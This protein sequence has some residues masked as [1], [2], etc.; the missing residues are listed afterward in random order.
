MLEVLLFVETCNKNE[1][2]NMRGILSGEDLSEEF[3]QHLLE[4]G[5]GTVLLDKYNC[6]DISLISTSV[7]SLD[8]LIVRVFRNFQD[9]QQNHMYLNERAI[10]Q[11]S[12]NPQ[13]ITA[14][15]INNKRLDCVSGNTRI[16]MYRFS[17]RS[18]RGCQLPR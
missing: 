1:P 11:K 2:K 13:N 6:L 15:S 18:C 8:E 3:A 12:N 16:Q 5:E 17:S 14:N 9:H 4:L 7:S 10:T